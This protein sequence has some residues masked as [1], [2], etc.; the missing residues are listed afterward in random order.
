MP[1][2]YCYQLFSNKNTIEV[3]GEGILSAQNMVKPSGGRTQHSPRSPAGW[4]GRLAAPPKNP[5]ICLHIC[6]LVIKRYIV[7]YELLRIIFRKW[8]RLRRVSSLLKSG[9]YPGKNYQKFN[10]CHPLSKLKSRIL[11]C[12]CLG[13]I[14]GNFFLATVLTSKD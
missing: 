11:S 14:F 9:P 5:T 8:L 2:T 7:S 13:R 1:V 3:S 10:S 6:R 12:S 4:L